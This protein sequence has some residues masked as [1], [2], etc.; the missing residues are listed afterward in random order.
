MTVKNDSIAGV[1]INALKSRPDLLIMIAVVA[2]FLY[3][4][5]RHDERETI[6]AHDAKIEM[7]TESKR[8][9][10]LTA[11]QMDAFTN[12]QDR[13]INQV[14]RIEERS[15][16]A[17]RQHSETLDTLVIEVKGTSAAVSSIHR[18]LESVFVANRIGEPLNIANNQ[19]K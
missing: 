1:L 5:D 19:N 13:V 10:A 9:D 17:I 4:L 7:A 12:L 11:R 8:R 16:E 6:A 2:G 14:D 15:I 18:M 3:Y